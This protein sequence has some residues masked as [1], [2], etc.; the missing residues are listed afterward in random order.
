M[1]IISKLRNDQALHKY[2]AQID[3]LTTQIEDLTAGFTM[4]SRFVMTLSA[5]ELKIGSLIKN[6]DSDWRNSKAVA[7]C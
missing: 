6:G 1:P 7:Y 2:G 4:D 3:V 5:A